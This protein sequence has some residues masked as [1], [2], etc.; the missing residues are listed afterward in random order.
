MRRQLTDIKALDGAFAFY[1][2]T[3]L[4]ETMTAKDMAA[5]DV[6]DLSGNALQAVPLALLRAI[7]NA[8][9]VNLSAN[10]LLS[11]DAKAF[12]TL[13]KL[14]E[15]SCSGTN[16]TALPASFVVGCPALE[17][18]DFSH[19]N[20][21]SLYPDSFQDLPKLHTLDLSFNSLQTLPVQLLP[22]ATWKVLDV[23]NNLLV[24]LPA[25]VASMKVTGY[26]S[27]EFNVLIEIEASQ[28]AGANAIR[29]L[30]LANNAIFTLY[31]HAF[32]GMQA[33]ERL[34]LS[35]NVLSMVD[36]T[37]F[38]GLVALTELLLS[39][40]NLRSIV[41]REFPPQLTRLDL[42]FNEID[43]FPTVKTVS[44]PT[45]NL[46]LLDLSWNHMENFSATTFDFC[47]DHIQTLQ[48]GNNLISSIPR[49]GFLE[50][51]ENPRVNIFAEG[52]HMSRL[53]LQIV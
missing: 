53:N 35:N 37:A 10:P 31:D 28:F 50:L 4:V 17:V 40:N 42:Q 25:D 44:V 45:H 20:L 19:G 3:M 12:N 21:S 14:V 18:I 30:R 49:T 15:I 48:L 9:R 11:L 41:F 7:T 29:E 6:I 36:P 1:R 39:D 16:L 8:S 27:F 47:K 43:V 46:D 32:A 33:L 22:L 38:D 23:S 13:P 26:A 2:N 51:F 5:Q 52:A 34:D 24:E